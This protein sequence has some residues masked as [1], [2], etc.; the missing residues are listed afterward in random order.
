MKP[1]FSPSL[2]FLN[3]SRGR[4]A[5][6]RTGH[7]PDLVFVSGLAS[8]HSL[9][10]VE[11]FASRFRVTVFDNLGC[12]QSDTPEIVSD[13]HALARD[14]A[15]LCEALG[16]KQADFVGH[17]MG[18]H[19]LQY[20]AAD[21]PDLVRKAA[22]VCSAATFS[23]VSDLA[24]TQQINLWQLGTPPQLLAA[25]YL[26][27]LFT[28]RFLG[29]EVRRNSYL[30][31]V[32]TYP[33]PPSLKGYSFQVEALRK[34]DSRSFLGRIQCPVLVL[35]CEKDLLTP[36]EQSHFLAREI[37]KAQLQVIPD[38]G[39]HPFLECP[40]LVYGHLNDFLT[41]EDRS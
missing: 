13:V 1:T 15:E 18:G 38:C 16:I 12:G 36:Q 20:L 33:Y 9:W 4:V 29:D 17:S 14:V 6:A 41:Q 22:M 30:E 28:P 40:D 21:Q 31:A 7:G 25:N 24:T 37:P 35:G 5:F 34:H 8:D 39:H 27:L 10:D 11:R 32:L 2:S 19:I 3:L 23:V 26:P